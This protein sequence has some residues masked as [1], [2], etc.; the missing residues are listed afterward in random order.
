MCRSQ[1]RSGVVNPVP[2]GIGSGTV[3]PIVTILTAVPGLSQETEYLVNVVHRHRN[4]SF[5]AFTR[6]TSDPGSKS[7]QIYARSGSCFA[8]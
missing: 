6:F 5:V 4:L 3:H 2:T 1:G 8:I 7:D